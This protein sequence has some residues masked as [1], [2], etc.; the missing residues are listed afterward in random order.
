M[1][2]TSNT[3]GLKYYCSQQLTWTP[4]APPGCSGAALWA[5]KESPLGPHRQN[6]TEEAAAAFQCVLSL[7]EPHRLW[8]HRHCLVDPLWEVPAGEWRCPA[9]GPG[10]WLSPVDD[11]IPVPRLRAAA[12]SPVL[13]PTLYKPGQHVMTRPFW[14]RHSSLTLPSGACAEGSGW[15]STEVAV[16][17]RAPSTLIGQS[18]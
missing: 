1:R 18:H 14:E 15:R 12:S 17:I 7:V 2:S 4:T 5:R 13:E 6:A 9:C 16:P 11:S 8:T 10:E 3:A